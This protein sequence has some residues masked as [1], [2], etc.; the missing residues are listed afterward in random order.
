LDRG[1]SGP[2]REPG[3]GVPTGDGA[4]VAAGRLRRHVAHLH[5][6]CRRLHQ[7]AAARDAEPVDDRQ[8]HPVEVPRAHRLSRGRCALVHPHG[9]DPRSG[10]P[11]CARV[12]HGKAD[13]MSVAAE[14]VAL[15]RGRSTAARAFAF[16]RRHALTLYALLA[17]SYLLVP[18]VVVVLFS[19]N[20]P[21]G[22]F[23][24]TWQGFTLDNWIHWDAVPGLRGAVELSLEIAAI[25]SVCATALG[26]LT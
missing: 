25:S 7:R 11:V 15:P 17:F 14:S 3:V 6:R 12:G 26:A 5:P 1:G 13:G 22:R 20:H 21:H 19:F 8:R 18:I 4:A 16:A 24:Y 10:R 23:N 9:H 2:L